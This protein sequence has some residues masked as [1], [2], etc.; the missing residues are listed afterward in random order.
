MGQSISSAGAESATAAFKVGDNTRVITDDG[1]DVVP[2]SGEIGRV[3]VG[4]LQPIGYYKDRR[5]RRPRSAIST[6][7]ATPC[8][9]TTPRSRPTA[10][11]PARPGLGVH[12]HRRREG[13]PG[14]GRGGAQDPRVVRDAVAVGVP[15]EK[16]GEAITAV[17]EL[18]PGR[19]STKAT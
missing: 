4:G 13:L 17:V 18:A 10:R 2:G 6:V 3:A 8:P 7:S 15:D 1:A 12:Q 14:G 9:A 11:S 16:F 19:G 5:S